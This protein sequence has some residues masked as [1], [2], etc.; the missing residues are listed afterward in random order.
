MK[1]KKAGEVTPPTQEKL[2]DVDRS[3][4]ARQADVWCD[5]YA[6]IE[7]KKAALVEQTEKVLQLMRTSKQRTMVIT[8]DLGFQHLFSVVE[9]G[10]K[11]R[12]S[13]RVEN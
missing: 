6:D 4:A 2:L 7:S 3:E 13:R 12:H 9:T 1:G 11:L 5:I 10:L 8:D